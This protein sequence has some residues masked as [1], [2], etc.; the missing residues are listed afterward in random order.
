MPEQNITE[1]NRRIARN[2]VLLYFRMGVLMLVGLFTSR[3]V[4]NALGVEDYGVYNVV[5]GMVSLMA[6]LTGSLSAAVSRFITYELGAGTKESLKKV[7]MS[8]V[9]VQVLFSIVI[10]LI[11]ESLGLWFL[12]HKMVIPESRLTAANWCFQFSVISFVIGLISVPYNAVIIAHE[13]MSAFAYISLFEGA[14]KLAIALLIALSPIDRLVFYAVLTAILAWIVRM[15]YASYCKR[16][17]EEARFRIYFEPSLLKKLF[18][19]AG[20][21]FFGAAS[22]MLMIQGMDILCNLFFGVTVNAARGIATQVD[23]AIRSFVNNFTT[24]INPQITK[25]YASKDMGYMFTLMFSGAKLSYFLVLLFAVPLLCET[26]AILSIWL[27]NV[28]DHA[29]SF[30]RLAT[31]ASMIS[32][33]SNTMITGM[34][35]TGNIKK[36]QLIIGGIGFM[37][38]PVAWG[39]FKTG[40]S[41][42]SAYFSILIIFMIQWI[43]RLFLLNELTGMSIGKYFRKVIRPV[44]IV[45]AVS[46]PLPLLCSYLIEIPHVR[47]IAAIATGMLITGAAVFFLG[48]TTEERDFILAQLNRRTYVWKK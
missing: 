11:A 43:C 14:G 38:L 30:V 33:L 24:A 6:I 25:S 20:W 40:F 16:H 26:P 3:V 47:I 46:F 27:K 28:P 29:V 34:L 13:R 10:V 44:V 32:V 9:T 36:Y 5:G 48:L 4:L 31:L 18:S 37:A 42:E 21:N 41:P 23:N 35:A 17:F 2:T 19:F 45:T 22:G 15:I 39:F 7:F 12:N 8:S 1:N